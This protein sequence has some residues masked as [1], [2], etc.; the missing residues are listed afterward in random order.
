MTIGEGGRGQDPICTDHKTQGTFQYTQ[1]K[2]FGYALVHVTTE[3]F[4]IDF[5]GLPL[6]KEEEKAI[7]KQHK[8]KRWFKSTVDWLMGRKDQIADKIKDDTIFSVIIDRFENEKVD[9]A[10]L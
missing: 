2:R 1:N 6:S 10:E 7:E 5:K 4:Q 9:E 3:K 8:N